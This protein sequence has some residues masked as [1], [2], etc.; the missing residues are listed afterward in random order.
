MLLAS[1]MEDLSPAHGTTP[2]TLSC[3]AIAH[4]P[5]LFDSFCAMPGQGGVMSEGQRSA[6]TRWVLVHSFWGKVRLPGGSFVQPANEIDKNTVPISAA[7][8]NRVFD[9]GELS[10]YAQWCGLDWR[11]HFLSMTASARKAGLNE[12]QVAFIAVLHGVGQGYVLEGL[13]EKC[14]DDGL[15]S[16]VKT[17]LAQSFNRM[18]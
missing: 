13:R 9:R 14:C 18:F 1:N 17:M 15:R 10:G 4:S 2:L 8:A 3:H 16:H 5:C 7:I 6:V 12:K 11:K